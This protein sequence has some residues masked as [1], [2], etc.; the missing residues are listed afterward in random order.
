MPTKEEKKSWSVGVDLPIVIFESAKET[1]FEIEFELSSSPLWSNITH[2]YRTSIHFAETSG[3]ICYLGDSHD[4]LHWFD[5]AT[6]KR[7][8]LAAAALAL[9]RDCPYRAHQST[10]ECL[11]PRVQNF[12]YKNGL[13]PP[14]Q[15]SHIQVA[16]ALSSA[17]YGGIHMSQW[18]S[19]FPSST[20]A[21][22]WRWS[23]VIIAASGVIA[24]LA[25]IVKNFF[26]TH[27]NVFAKK[28]VPSKV[29]NFTEDVEE[30]VSRKHRTESSP[31]RILNELILACCAAMIVACV[32]LPARC[33]VIV[34]AFISL[35]SLPVDAFKTPEW[36]QWI[37]HI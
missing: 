32:Y 15:E 17:L 33:F 28:S 14:S 9:E 23:T 8:G 25:M 19:H 16:V 21:E 13:L 36:S 34:E 31:N 20:E 26:D 11:V 29:L 27:A 5:E 1:N 24:S 2:V 12:P 35:R 30:L 4:G 37:P 7:W 18:F 22:L 6:F 10:A 3:P